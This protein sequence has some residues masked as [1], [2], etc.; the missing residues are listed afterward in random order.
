MKMSSGMGV[1]IIDRYSDG[2]RGELRRG[3]KFR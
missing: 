3:V 1:D 2:R